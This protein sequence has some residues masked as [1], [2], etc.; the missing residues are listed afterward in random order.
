MI[1]PKC[2]ANLPE[3]SVFCPNCGCNIEEEK[4]LIEKQKVENNVQKKETIVV[5]KSPTNKKLVALV[6]VVSICC[7]ALGFYT[8]SLSNRIT[9][10]LNDV[11]NSN[12]SNSIDLLSKN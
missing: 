3:D 9:D 2:N 11:T 10:A 1:C 5:Q 12:N 6:I 7:C 4:Q 8:F